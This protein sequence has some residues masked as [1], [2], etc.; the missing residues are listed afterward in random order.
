MNRLPTF[1][2]ELMR[3]C[4]NLLIN[5]GGIKQGD[6]VVILCELGTYLDPV[7]VDAQA[8]VIQEVG[9]TPHILWTPKLQ[10]TWWED[11]SEVVRGAVGN[12]DV[13]VQNIYTIG[14]T[15]LLDLML[16]KGVRRIR[17]Y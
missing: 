11:L 8:T 13:V 17:N 7:I 4:H 16:N 2:P 6:Q 5:Y 15:H 1:P 9:A 10:K 12:A 3:G 14:K